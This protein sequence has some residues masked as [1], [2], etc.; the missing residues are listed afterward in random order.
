MPGIPDDIMGEAFTGPDVSMKRPDNVDRGVLT[1]KMQDMVSQVAEGAERTMMSTSSFGQPLEDDDSIFEQLMPDN[2]LRG[3]R[4]GGVSGMVQELDDSFTNLGRTLLEYRPSIMDWWNILALL[5]PILITMVGLVIG[6]AAA[7]VALGA[8]AATILGVGLLGWGDSLGESFSNLQTEAKDLASTLFDVLQPAAQAFRPMQED[9]LEAVPGRIA[10]LVGPMQELVV[11]GD[12]LASIGDGFID[13]MEEGIKASTALDEEIG[14]ILIRFGGAFGDFLIN[15]LRTMVRE[16]YRNQD[17][18]ARLAGIL[19]DAVV[20]IFNVVKAV[21][22]A[23]SNFKLLFDILAAVSGFLSNKFMVAILTGIAGLIL[24]ET[25]L[26]SVTSLFAALMSLSG[27]MVVAWASQLFPALWTLVTY[28]EAVFIALSQVYGMWTAL[29]AATGGLLALAAGAGA[30][31][32]LAKSATGGRDVGGSVGQQQSG[33][34]TFIN[35][36]GDVE[37]RQM[38]RLLDKVPSETRGEMAMQQGMDGGR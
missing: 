20:S 25:V 22:F 27:A 21:A 34:N 29:A 33:G 11:F 26:A 16:V 5:I 7:F 19:L 4:R 18:Y 9:L 15:V 23:I 13:W 6:L 37:K 38:D 28:L 10:D 30:A 3:R 24:L 31:F 36:E 2:V 32:G 8:A 35:V 14:Q 12:E 1:T 17:A